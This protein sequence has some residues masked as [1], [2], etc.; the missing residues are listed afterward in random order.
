MGAPQALGMGSNQRIA[1]PTMDRATILAKLEEWLA[2]GE[3]S[4]ETYNKLRKKYE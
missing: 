2:M 4:E 1:V 3:I